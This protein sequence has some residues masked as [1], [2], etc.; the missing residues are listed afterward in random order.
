MINKETLIALGCIL[1]P[2][3]RVMVTYTYNLGRGRHL[4]FYE[5]GTPNEF[6]FICETDPQVENNITES[7]CLHNF[8]YDGYLTEERAKELIRLLTF[9]TKSFYK[10]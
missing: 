2:N 1:D 8:D 4:S 10:S 7:I 6:V 5:I 9:K 3:N